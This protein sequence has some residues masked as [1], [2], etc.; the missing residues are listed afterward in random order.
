MRRG[1]LAIAALLGALPA[2]SGCLIEGTVD[3]AGGGTLKVSARAGKDMSLDQQKRQFA[4]PN[5][6]ITNATM[7]AEKHFVV[8]LNYK[9]LAKLPMSNFFRNLVVTSGTDATAGTRTVLARQVNKNP[10]KLAPD[11][12]QYFGEDVTVSM[13]LPGDVVKT[14]ATEHKGRTVT[15]KTTLTKLLGEKETPFEVTYKL[16][17]AS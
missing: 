1:T 3:A 2:V 13:T 6:T 9:D 4:S 15:W 5:V 10:S 7:D 11:L 8:D 17:P 14:N 12:L 16:P